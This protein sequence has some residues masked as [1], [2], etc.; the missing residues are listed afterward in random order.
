VD[1]SKSDLPHIVIPHDQ[2]P[3]SKVY[4]YCPDCHDVFGILK[5]NPADCPKCGRKELKD[6]FAEIA[7]RLAKSWSFFEATRVK[8]GAWL[9]SNEI[10]GKVHHM[11]EGAYTSPN[12]PLAYYAELRGLGFIPPWLDPNDPD[13]RKK[14]EEFP[15]P[16]KDEAFCKS[17]SP[18][19][20]EPDFATR[21][22]TLKYFNS[23][24]WAKDP[25]SACGRIGHA[26]DL[27][28]AQRRQ[29]GKQDMDDIYNYV[30]EL[31]DTQYRVGKGYWGGQESGFVSRTSGNMKI[32]C[33]YARFDWPI[34]E[35]KQIIDYHLGEATEKA[36]FEGSGCSAFNQMHPLGGIYRQYPELREYRRDEIDYYTSKTFM[37]FLSNW[38]DE[39]NFYG[40]TWIGKHNNGVVAHMT[41]LL[42]DLPLC[43][44]STYYN[45]RENPLITR[46][47][48]GTIRRNDVI[49]QK[50]GF[51]FYG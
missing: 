35:P 37:T 41:Q 16:R 12:Y 34:P 23:L 2:W 49:Y 38:D 26:L 5:T 32:L 43:R 11:D 14:E 30:K 45:W 47:E 7:E 31:I 20:V 50:K 46:N 27:Y 15:L 44:V 9:F 22:S 21:E 28:M 1:Y 3:R 33:T 24:P 4:Y 51:R 48:D 17:L 13:M 40:K 19:G 36:G 8:K 29:A 6:I 18:G 25:Y 42:L 39:T 10:G